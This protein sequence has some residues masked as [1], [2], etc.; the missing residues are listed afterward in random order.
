MLRR[1]HAS[2]AINGKRMATSKYF[3]KIC[4][5]VT[6]LAV[7]LT[8]LFMNGKSLGIEAASGGSGYE[9]RLFD[10]SYVHEIDVVIDDFD[11]MCGKADKTWHD[12]NAVID[13]E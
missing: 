13:G 11:D 5:I 12:C 10:T 4:I 2:V 1:F 7:L 6:A 9:D 3:D 8:V